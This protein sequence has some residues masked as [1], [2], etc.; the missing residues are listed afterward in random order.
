[1]AR[2][3]GMIGNLQKFKF[4]ECDKKCVQD[5]MLSMI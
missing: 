1:M 2:I 4:Q 5:D 3:N